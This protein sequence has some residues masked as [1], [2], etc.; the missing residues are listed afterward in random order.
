MLVNK[1]FVPLEEY[2]FSRFPPYITAGAVLLS[3]PALEDIHYASYFVKHFRFDDIFVAL[4]AKKM[5]LIPIH[6]EE[7][8]FHERQSETPEQD[9]VAAHGFRDPEKLLRFWNTQRDHFYA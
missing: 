6:S 3:K 5:G 1:W 2:P 4:C 9:L 8:R 7:F